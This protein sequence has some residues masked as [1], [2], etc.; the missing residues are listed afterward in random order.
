MTFADLQIGKE[1]TMD[2]DGESSLWMKTAADT[3][4]RTTEDDWWRPAEKVRG[5][6]LVIPM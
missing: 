2:Q 3:A 1:F 4:E 5:D 6:T